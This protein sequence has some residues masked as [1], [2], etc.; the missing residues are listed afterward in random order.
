MVQL[1]VHRMFQNILFQGH[2]GFAFTWLLFHPGLLRS[3][4]IIQDPGNFQQSVL[5]LPVPRKRA[6]NVSVPD[7]PWWRCGLSDLPLHACMS[8]Q[9]LFQRVLDLCWYIRWSVADFQRGFKYLCCRLPIFFNFLFLTGLKNLR[10]STGVALRDITG[11]G[12]ERFAS[13]ARPTQFP[14]D[15]KWDYQQGEPAEADDY[16]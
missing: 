15:K 14:K 11:I 12:S 9:M 1:K 10:R 7:L 5:A 3:Q 13:P 2:W 6:T 4:W 16:C 8:D